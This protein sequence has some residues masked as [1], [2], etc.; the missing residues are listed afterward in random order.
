MKDIQL[1]RD[2]RKALMNLLATFEKLKKDHFSLSTY[3]QYCN[4]IS[5]LLI[6]RQFDNK[7]IIY[8]LI[9]YVKIYE[10]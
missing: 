1:T 4:Y 8:I 6:R 5:I 10:N 2:F 7:N 9:M 3:H